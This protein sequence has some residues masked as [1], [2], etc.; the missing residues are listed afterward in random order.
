MRACYYCEYSYEIGELHGV[1]S[2]GGKSGIE[3]I[4]LQVT[5]LLIPFVALLPENYHVK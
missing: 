2:F 1:V 5:L 4:I 3:L